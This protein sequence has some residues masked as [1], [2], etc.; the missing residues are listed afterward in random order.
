M[1]RNANRPTALVATLLLGSG[2]CALAYQVV[3]FREFRLV[4]G[5]ST[6]ASAAVLA[7]FMGGIGLGGA[8]LGQK[9]DKH[10]SPLRLYGWLELGVAVAAALSPALISLTQS[11]YI[12][13][14]GQSVLGLWGATA[15]R[16][17]LA[18]V[19]LG[20]PTFLMGGTLPAAVRAATREDDRSR[21]A[22]A[23]LYGVNTLGAVLGA[24]MS[25]F[26]LLPAMSTHSVLWLACG[27]NTV[28]GLVAVLAAPRNEMTGAAV[29]S[30]SSGA[31]APQI[32]R[33]SRELP[34]FAPP[35]PAVLVYSA[36]CVVGFAFFLMELVWYRMLG[37]ILGGTTYTF[38]L[39]LVVALLGIGIGGA[40]Y[41]FVLRR[42]QPSALGF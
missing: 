1:L 34:D 22:T 30:G 19:V 3:W 26:V 29:E 9:A 15:A 16:L 32:T 35:E 40:L 4:F 17:G 11:A 31:A 7:V 28:V 23:L 10:P 27:L 41:S 25:T 24:A 2:F 18:C 37:P 6:A 20:L 39:I 5:A 36:A 21:H 12:A 33:S 13:S 38:G 42:V 14:G 8:L